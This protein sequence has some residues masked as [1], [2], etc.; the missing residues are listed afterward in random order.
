MNIKTFLE[1]W[2]IDRDPF[3]DEEARHDEVLLRLIDESFEHF[4]MPKILGDL[5]HPSSAVVFGEKGSG[6]TAIR[7]QIEA[8]ID[9]HNRKHP[10]ER[11]FMIAYDDLNPV[12]DRLARRTRTGDSLRTLRA[13]TLNDHIDGILSIAVPAMVDRALVRNRPQGARPAAGKG[14]DGMAIDRRSLGWLERNVRSDL[15]LLQVLYDRSEGSRERGR[16]LARRLRDWRISRVRPL[17]WLAILLWV[18]FAVGGVY[19]GFFEPP[20]PAWAAMTGLGALGALTLGVS[21]LAFADWLR[22]RRIARGL[23]HQLRV[24]DRDVEWFRR[25]LERLPR[26]LLDSP[27]LPVDDLDEAR[28]ELLRRFCRAT[29][30]LG[31][32]SVIV[33]VDRVD[34]PTLVNGE[35]SRMQAVVWPMLNNKFLQQPGFAV[36]MMLPIELRFAVQAESK[37]FFQAARLDKQNMIE[38]LQ[39]SGPTLYDLCNRRIRAC[40]KDADE[41]AE[42]LSLCDLFDDETSRT[43]V[44]ATLD[45]MRQPRDAFKLLHQ[46]MRHHCES[47]TEEDA[48]WSIPKHIVD[49]V[50]DRR[51]ERLDAF[52]CGLAPA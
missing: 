19:A 16:A 11:V 52:R 31:F 32:V 12:L 37:D 38:R 35:T 20:G 8:R 15:R 10:D 2:R 13:M 27:I 7:M 21:G 40:M 6:K 47:V 29:S 36:K 3:M 51:K 18:L 43:D 30:Q 39:W 24:L 48:V 22:T 4:E 1:Y 5:R 9:A 46:I 25:G 34:E 14:A 45:Q 42:P 41:H 49:D 17:R 50:L 28:Y 44:L 33:L 26:E 23:S